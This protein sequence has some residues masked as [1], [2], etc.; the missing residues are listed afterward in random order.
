M[1]KVGGLWFA[2]GIANF[3]SD[4]CL[5][6][7]QVYTSTENT[8]GWI[9]DTIAELIEKPSSSA[10]GQLEESG[11]SSKPQDEP[12]ATTGTYQGRSQGGVGGP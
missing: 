4:G 10:Q 1:C 11:F 7:P 12:N 5:E 3:I 8:Q 6:L 9:N 2:Y